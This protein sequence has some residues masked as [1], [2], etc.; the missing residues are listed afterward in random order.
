[1]KGALE[2]PL[3]IVAVLA[4]QALFF[5]S[6]ILAL[7]IEPLL[8]V[9]VFTT[10]I[11]VQ[12]L[13]IAHAMSKIGRKEKFVGLIL[14]EFYSAVLSLALLVFYILPIKMDWKGR[15]YASL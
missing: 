14:Y 11:L 1:M 2:L 9:F 13:F 6:L 5:P 12:S 7:F 8:G 3:T 10:K 15:K 4:I